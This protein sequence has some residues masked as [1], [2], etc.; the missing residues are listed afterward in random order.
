MEVPAALQNLIRRRSATLWSC[1]SRIVVLAAVF[2][3][4]CTG[5]RQPRASRAAQSSDNQALMSEVTGETRLSVEDTVVV[6]SFAE[7]SFWF[8]SPRR[9]FPSDVSTRLWAIDPINTVVANF[10]LTG[11]AHHVLADEGLG[12][13]QLMTPYALVESDDKIVIL[14]IRTARIAAFSLDGALEFEIPINAPVHSFAG[15]PSDEFAVVPGKDHLVDL[16]SREGLIGSLGPLRGDSIRCS[17]CEVTNSPNGDLVVAEPD[18]PRLRVFDDQDKQWTVVD[19]RNKE[20]RRWKSTFSADREHDRSGG[21]A[22]G[23]VRKLWIGQIVEATAE[24][25]SLLMYAPR[26]SI[27]GNEVWRVNLNTGATIRLRLDGES[28]I[29]VAQEDETLFGLLVGDRGIVRFAVGRNPG[30]TP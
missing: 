2:I 8:Q 4:A 29:S 30:G 11:K 7:E 17:R 20:M 6:P 23:V 19:L 26:P 1:R 3:V 5:D 13:Q 28:I 25:V 24:E 10:D 27:D 16:Y 21:R 9:L 18:V 14:D 15:L 12:P 22:V